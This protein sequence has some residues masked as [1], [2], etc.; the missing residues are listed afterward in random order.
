MAVLGL[1][2]RSSRSCCKLIPIAVGDM[3]TP[4]NSPCC[5]GVGMDFISFYVSQNL[6]HKSVRNAI[7]A[8]MS[9][10]DTTVSGYESIQTDVDRVPI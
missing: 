8:P 6:H 4:C 9:F 10:F 7:Y 2:K 1:P 5:S 3:L